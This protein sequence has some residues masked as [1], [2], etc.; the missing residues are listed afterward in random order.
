V[1]RHNHRRES[2]RKEASQ[3]EAVQMENP[4][5]EESAPPFGFGSCWVSEVFPE[6]LL[7]TKKAEIVEN[8][9]KGSKRDRCG[10]DSCGGRC[11]IE[12]KPARLQYRELVN[13]CGGNN[14]R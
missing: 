1:G 4:L 9:I 5:D 14:A 2:R 12:V 10:I 13:G 7:L 6:I 3:R 8:L 11:N